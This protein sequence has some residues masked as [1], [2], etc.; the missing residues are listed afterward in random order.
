MNAARWL[1]N[2]LQGNFAIRGDAHDWLM[3][4]WNAIQVF[5]D[6]ADGAHPDREDLTAAIADTLVNMPANPF[7]RAHCDTLFPLM[8]VAILKWRAADDAERARHPTEMSYAWRAGFYDVVLA[9]V[10]IVHG[11]EVAKDAAQ[12]VMNLYGENYADYAKEFTDA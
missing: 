3:S 6:M 2:H 5:D 4:L 8:A 9:V 11:F 12:H 10:Q 1:S 7:F